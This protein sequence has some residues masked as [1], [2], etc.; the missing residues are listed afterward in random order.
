MGGRQD[1][2]EQMKSEPEGQ[3]FFPDSA[4]NLPKG[5]MLLETLFKNRINQTYCN[6]CHRQSFTAAGHL[7]L[8]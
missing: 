8:K 2:S 6:M 3:K 5:F 1:R 4:G 7:G